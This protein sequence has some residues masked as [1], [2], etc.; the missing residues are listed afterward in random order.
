MTLGNS[1]WPLQP[2]PL[3]DVGKELTAPSPTQVKGPRNQ[4]LIAPTF[5]LFAA[6]CAK[7]VAR[8]TQANR[9][10]LYPGGS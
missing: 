8:F 10:D 3:S 6:V 7:Q 4:L 5:V 1:M 9:S 2:V